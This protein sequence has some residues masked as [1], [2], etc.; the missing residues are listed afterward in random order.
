MT[1]L[2]AGGETAHRKLLEAA[3]KR[4]DR[5]RQAL[6]RVE[7]EEPEET[8]VEDHRE[9]L[10]P[11]QHVERKLVSMLEASPLMISQLQKD[12]RPRAR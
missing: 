7:V 6:A 9:A 8:L 4:G 11:A 3:L 1:N 10:R 12:A 2:M 5:V